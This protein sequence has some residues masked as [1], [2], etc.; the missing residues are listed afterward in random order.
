MWMRLKSVMRPSCGR[1]DR[2][3]LVAGEAARH[4]LQDIVSRAGVERCGIVER[5]LG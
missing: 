5:I 1:R 4:K 2:K 3:Q